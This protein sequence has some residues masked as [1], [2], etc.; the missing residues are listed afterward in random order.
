ML[1]LPPAIMCLGQ[2]CLPPLPALLFSSVKWGVWH[3][4]PRTMGFHGGWEDKEFGWNVGDLGSISGL[5]RSPREGNG[6]PLQYSG[7]ENS[8]DRGAL[9]GYSPWGCKESDMTEWPSHTHTQRIMLRFKYE[10]VWEAPSTVPGTEQVPSL[11][12]LLQRSR[13]HPQTSSMTFSPVNSPWLF[14]LSL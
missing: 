6:N 3:L 10:K 2:V 7:L 1:A 11:H 8:M 12:N 14:L 4:P 5:G 13:Q 9:A